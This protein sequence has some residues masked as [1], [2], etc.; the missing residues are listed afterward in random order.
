VTALPV[1]KGRPLMNPNIL[2]FIMIV[3]VASCYLL[4]SLRGGVKQV[5]S[6]VVMVGSFVAASRFYHGIAAGFP[7]KVFPESFSDASAWVILFLL[8]FGGVSLVGK[9]L[10]DLFK[11]LHF[12]G[13]DRVVS[14]F[15][16]LF[17]GLFLAC[18]AMAIV[19]IT[20][21]PETS[22]IADSA[23]APYLMPVAGGIVKLLPKEE[24][25]E[26]HTKARELRDLWSTRGER[27]E[28]E[29]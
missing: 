22:T 27:E 23:G 1:T 29:E 6:T 25:E 5:F 11:R 17:K 13:I 10:D 15:L 3:F 4:S 7:K 19:I 2:D 8:I 12:G 21:P 28:G 14:I 18:A 26:F 16:G 20:Y 24:Q 9:F